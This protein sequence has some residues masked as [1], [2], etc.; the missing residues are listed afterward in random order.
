MFHLFRR[1][2]HRMQLSA[3]VTTAICTILSFSLTAAPAPGPRSPTDSLAAIHLADGYE[4]ELIISEPLI[5][6]PV[7]IDFGAD[8]RLW[9]AEMFDYPTGLDNKGKP[10]GR[11]KVLSSSKDD[12]HFDK[13]TLI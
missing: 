13:A 6:S 2:L 3:W 11:I 12:G 1:I 5:Q 7:A 4:A 10:G 8:G 9:V